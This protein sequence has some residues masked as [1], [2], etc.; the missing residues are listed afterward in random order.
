MIA[1]EFATTAHSEKKQNKITVK[2]V[3]LYGCCSAKAGMALFQ[4][5]LLM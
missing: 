3:D 2:S 1:E 4:S 5:T